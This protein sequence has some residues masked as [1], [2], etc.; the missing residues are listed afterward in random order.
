MFGILQYVTKYW[1][2]GMDTSV[3]LEERFAVALGVATQL[4]GL[5]Q[6]WGTP[7]LSLS[8]HSFKQ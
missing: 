8:G 3:I 2:C 7:I 1:V 5:S 6:G 4:Y